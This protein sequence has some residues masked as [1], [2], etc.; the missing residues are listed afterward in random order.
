MADKITIRVPFS[1]SARALGRIGRVGEN[2]SRRILFDCTSA[3]AG[4]ASA[5]ITCVI[6]RPSYDDPYLAPIEE[7]DESGVYSLTLRDVDVAIAGTVKIELRMLDGDEIL[8]AAIYTGIVEPSITADPVDPGNPVADMLDKLETAADT[9][10]EAVKQIDVAVEKAESAVAEATT[11]VSNANE[12]IASANAATETAETAANQATTAASNAQSVA[13]AVQA[14]LDAGEFKGDK[15][16]T[17]ATGATGADGADGISP[18]VSTS[19]ADGVTTVTITDRDGT[20]TATINDGAKGEKGD[21]GATGA[22][23][24]S[25]TATVS[26]SG[27]TTTVTVTDKNG[28]TT[29]EVLDGTDASVTKENVVSALGYEP[30]ERDLVYINSIITD[31]ESTKM[32]NITTD[33]QGNSFRLKR[34]LVLIT[35][36]TASG[37]NSLYC[38]LGDYKWVAYCYINTCTRVLFDVQP[39]GGDTWYALMY[40]STSTGSTVTYNASAST[41]GFVT[42]DNT[43][44]VARGVSCYSNVGIPTGTKIDVYGI[45]A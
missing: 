43:D 37:D 14:K 31:A 4:R 20:H 5:T 40:R 30:A 35:L 26:K 33:A 16:D 38:G 42:V 15:G 7:T 25:P 23:G 41:S 22:D 11:A 28:T 2:V 10:N 32:A 9:A 34:I 12:A 39:A 24:Y 36:P 44:G 6:Q 18:T 8:K 1:Q 29:A 27:T 19:K 21:T 17:G 13:D 45:R 3:L